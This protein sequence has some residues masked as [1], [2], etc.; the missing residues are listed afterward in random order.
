MKRREFIA[1]IS[2]AAWPRV[3]QAQQRA[4]PM[5]GYLS[6]SRLAP[7]PNANFL[8]GLTETGYFDGRNVTIDFRSAEDQNDR[9]TVLALG[10]ANRQVNV[11][12]AWGSSTVVLAAKEATQKIPIVFFIGGDPVRN[13]FVESFARPGRNMTGVTVTS[14]ELS[15][16]RLELLHELIPATT[17][18]ALLVN[19]TSP[20]TARGDTQ[21]AQLAATSLGVTLQV[22]SASSPDDFEPAFISAKRQGA[23]ALL[24]G[25]DNLFGAES[26]RII[27]LAMRHKMP[28]MYQNRRSAVLGGLISYAANLADL[29]RQCGVY[30]GRILK[31]EKPTDLPVQQPTKFE[32]VLNLKTAKA[33]GVEVPSSILV[34]ADEVIE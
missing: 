23:G 1:G 19:Q 11:L 17:S 6:N 13:G 30:T 32:L 16:K 12:V 5:V 3:A 15:T 8:E 20:P 27:A 24:L 22:V 34:R 28:T 14:S 33:L 10:L 2:P 29:Q 26:R 4:M 31:G 7:A 18:I 9:L 21:Y 25:T